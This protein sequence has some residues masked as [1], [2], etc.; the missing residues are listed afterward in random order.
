MRRA[1]LPALTTALRDT[2]QG[3]AAAT[4]RGRAAPVPAGKRRL[5]GRVA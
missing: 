1:L 3:T 2:G 4:L 5:P